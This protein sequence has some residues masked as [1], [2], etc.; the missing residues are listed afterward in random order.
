[1]E[2]HALSCVLW[3]ARLVPMT[4]W[5]MRFYL[6]AL[7]A[8]YPPTP[9]LRLEQV[10]E[11]GCRGTLLRLGPETDRR[12]LLWHYGGA[13]I[14]GDVKGNLGLAERYGRRC[15]CDVFLVNYRRCP[16]HYVEDAEED[17]WRAYCWLTK[18][19]PSSRICLLGISSGGGLSVRTMQRC[20]SEGVSLPAGAAL[21]S[22]WVRWTTP[23][24]SMLANQHVDLIVTPRVVAQVLALQEGMF[25]DPQRKRSPLHE[26]LKGLPHLYVSVSSHEACVDE[27]LA[28]VQKAKASGVVVD[29]RAK[30]FLPHAF[31]LLS[32]YLPEALEVEHDVCAWINERWL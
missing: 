24:A 26:P 13:M 16:E 14:A 8:S 18:R 31:Q 3:W 28:F 11:A 5:R 23:A 12:I 15:G 10:D 2:A 4:V 19:V 7:D 25:R 30:D 29:L 1:M 6:G 27:D 22:P 32:G 9:G 21:L 20:V 17:C